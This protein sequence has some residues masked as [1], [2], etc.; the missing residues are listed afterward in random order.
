[1]TSTTWLRPAAAILAFALAIA[2]APAADAQSYPTKP[3]RLV[4]PTGA[5]GI[6]DIVS[7]LIGQKLTE[8]WGQQVVVDNRPG[9][10][11]IIGSEIVAKAPPDGYTLLMAF[12]SHP[13]NPA[14]YAKLPYDSI[15]DFEPV[16]KVTTVTLVLVVNPSVP[17]KSVKELI[18][19][20]KAQPGKLNYGTV[21]TGSLG[22]LGAVVFA[23]MAGVDIVQ[24]PYKGA[25]QVNAALLS[26]EVSMFFDAP[27]TALPFIKAG[28]VRALAVS[29][30][31]RSAVM[32]EIPTMA[33]AGLPGYDVVGWLGILAPAK[34][35]KAIVDKLNAEVVKILK[36][37]D[38]RERLAAQAVEIVGSTPEQFATSIKSDIDKFTKIARDAGMKA[39]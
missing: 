14:L 30:P 25:P 19:L 20:A 38:V 28:K 11:G 5:G 32:P 37:P 8:S 17:A 16:V 23:K 33:E 6:N 22:H 10:G 9:A 15:A 29:S 1:M 36:M 31:T 4:V 39:E 24:V 21:G 13:V 27:V 3:I 7:R 26:G 18:A 12:S 34:T 2:A 35:P